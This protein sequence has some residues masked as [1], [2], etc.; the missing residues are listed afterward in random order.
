MST[1]EPLASGRDADVY[2]RGEG[3]VARRYRD[4]R[5]AAAE[6]EVLRRVHA[7]G[8]PV[9]ALHAVDGPELVMQRVEGPTLADALLGGRVA[10][11][12]AGGLIAE[13]HNRLHRLEWPGGEPLLHLDLH[14]LNVIVAATGPVVIDWTNARPGPAGLDAAVTALIFGQLVVLPGMAGGPP[15][16]DDVVRSIATEFLAAFT[17]RVEGGLLDHLDAAAALR[18]AD[19]NTSEDEREALVTAVA[20]VR[21]IVEVAERP[22]LGVAA[23]DAEAV[24]PYRLAWLRRGTASEVVEFPGDDDPGTVHLLATAPDGTAAGVATWMPVASPDRPGEPALQLRGMAVD[25]TRRRQ[26]VGRALIDA[27]MALAAERGLAWVWA[28]ARDSALAF[29]TAAGFAVVGEGFV[30]ADTQLPHHRILRR[31]MTQP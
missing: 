20:V 26:G 30:T 1:H 9:P 28:N 11:T 6:A 27:G 18:G 19:R 3:L 13:L 31:V 24:R 15:E 23:V 21:G 22:A 8:Y 14:P 25:P 17:A 12:E 2:A 7:L 4:G 10:A 16:F 5:S 29:Y